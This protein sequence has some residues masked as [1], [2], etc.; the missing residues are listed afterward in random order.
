LCTIV[1]W[2]V[3]PE[4][5]VG[6]NTLQV[7]VTWKAESPGDGPGS[8]LFLTAESWACQVAEIVVPMASN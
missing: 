3:D 2:I 7:L 8:L 1:S 5:P 6:Y 4:T